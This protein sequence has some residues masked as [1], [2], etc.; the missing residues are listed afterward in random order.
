M[1]VIRKEIVLGFQTEHQAEI[2]LRT[3][4]YNG[5]KVLDKYFDC[6][7]REIIIVL[8]YIEKRGNE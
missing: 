8:E 7:D 3:R 2:E 5:W 1:R 4:L 6:H